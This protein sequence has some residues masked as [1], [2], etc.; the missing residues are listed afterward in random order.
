LQHAEGDGGGGGA[1]GSAE[2]VDVARREI[3]EGGEA[4][5]PLFEEGGA[6]D[7]DEGG[8]AALGEEGTGYD[9]FARAGRGD[10]HA[11][12]VREEGVERGL[13]GGL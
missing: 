1:L 2:A 11:V 5:T 9:G 13:L 10:E 4:L 7:E 8:D 12:V 3:E 6:V